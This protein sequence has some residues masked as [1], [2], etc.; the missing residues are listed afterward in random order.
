M[1]DGVHIK[2]LKRHVDDRGYLLEI[3]RDDD[4]LFQKFG[5]AY[6]TAGFPGI[7]KAWHMHRIQ[8][9]HFCVVHGNM[10]VGLYDDREG[11]PTCGEVQ[12]LVIGDL[13]PALV[14]IPPLVWHGMAAVGGE[15]AVLLNVPTEHY[16]ATEPDEIRR[17]PFDPAIPFEWFTKGG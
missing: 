11:S 1:I 8:T 10:K 12:S 7:V 5:Q 4:P 14:V 9:D 15:T 16:D 2:P 6:I 17:D 3:L 13:N